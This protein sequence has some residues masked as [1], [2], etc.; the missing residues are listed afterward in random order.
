MSKA[1]LY[2]KIIK[3]MDTV[4]QLQKDGDIFD[5]KGK[6]MYAYLSE[7]RTTGELQRAFIECGIVLFPVKV[8]SEVIYLESMK[9]DVEVKTPITKVI[10]TYKICDSETGEYEELQSIGYGSDSQDKGSN[11]AM[12]SSFK[13]VQR[14]T[15]MISTGDDSDHTGSDELDRK[16]LEKVKVEG[17]PLVGSKEESQAVGAKKLAE[18]QKAKETHTQKVEVT[19]EALQKEIYNM[20]KPKG[21]SFPDLNEFASA[22]LNR[23]VKFFKKD[24]VALD[25]LNKVIRALNGE[26][27]EAIY[28]DAEEIGPDDPRYLPF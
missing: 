24:V 7:E 3:V 6:K 26:V 12:T 28:E 13:Y 11:K 2:Q 19:T 10:V 15:F 9:Y 23:Q 22:T 8:E 17:I 16:Q 4:G 25:D 27:V 18:A 1:K 5:N 21:M 14:Q 20:L